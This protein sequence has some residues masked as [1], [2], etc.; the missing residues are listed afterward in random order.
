MQDPPAPSAHP[1][2]KALSILSQH[3]RDSEREIATCRRGHV[4]E[5]A[6]LHNNVPQAK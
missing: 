1:L 3:G 4:Y 2:L 5:V 6:S